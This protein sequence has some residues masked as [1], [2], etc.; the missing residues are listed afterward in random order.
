MGLDRIQARVFHVK[1]AESLQAIGSLP[2]LLPWAP[3][4]LRYSEEGKERREGRREES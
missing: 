1:V 4:R 3:G 2:A